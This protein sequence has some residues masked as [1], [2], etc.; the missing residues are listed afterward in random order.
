MING[1]NYNYTTPDKSAAFGASLNF[2]VKGPG[3][4]RSVVETMEALYG[5]KQT[6]PGMEVTVLNSTNLNEATLGGD[7]RKLVVRKFRC[8]V[9]KEPVGGTARTT[10]PTD[11]EPVDKL[12]TTLV[13][14][15]LWN[16]ALN[17]PNLNDNTLRATLN[18]GDYYVVSAA[19]TTEVDS[20]T[21]WDALDVVFFDKT[22]GTFSRVASTN[23]VVSEPLYET[24][25]EAIFQND[26]KVLLLA[27]VLVP[28]VVGKGYSIGQQVYVSDGTA[29]TIYLKKT[30]GN[31]PLTDSNTW[32]KVSTTNY[33]DLA[34]KPVLADQ[35]TTAATPGVD[36]MLMP[37]SE[38]IRRIG[39][40]GTS[41]TGAIDGGS[42]SDFGL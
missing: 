38:V 20:Q 31:V 2:D 13:A 1:K 26:V 25:E 41:Y 37:A 17:S 15:G 7:L 29:T 19:G 40:G 6:Y 12:N 39:E 33:Q 11:W 27:N 5:L 4:A 36:Q 16:A 35:A 24:G 28:Y 10:E 21:Q 9:D 14:K 22:L 30:G 23:P 3:D 18:T 32:T 8:L 34:N 42:A